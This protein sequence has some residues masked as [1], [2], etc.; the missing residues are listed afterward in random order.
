MELERSLVD[1]IQA[2]PGLAKDGLAQP[3]SH[4]RSVQTHK[5]NG[6]ASLH[7]VPKSLLGA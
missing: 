5:P 2:V 6:Q 4:P 3:V 1:E 7:S